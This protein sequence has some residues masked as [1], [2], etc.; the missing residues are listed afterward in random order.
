MNNT[1]K[2]LLCI[3]P[4]IVTEAKIELLKATG[5]SNLSKLVTQLLTE[6]TNKQKK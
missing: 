2:F 5:H 1:K 3:E 4:T 6:W